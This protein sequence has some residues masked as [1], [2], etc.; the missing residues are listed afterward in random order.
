M[1]GEEDTA[2]DDRDIFLMTPT[3]PPILPSIHLILISLGFL[4]IFVAISDC[5]V[6]QQPPLC[7]CVFV[8][9]AAVWCVVNDTVFE[10]VF[11]AA[12]VNLCLLMS[13][14]SHTST[15]VK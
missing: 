3:I 12:V 13:P 14:F 7:S 15:P 10:Y 8:L 2:C 4:Y 6:G 1:T 11:C 9:V 5:G